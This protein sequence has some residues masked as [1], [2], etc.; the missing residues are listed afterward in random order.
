MQTEKPTKDMKK[1]INKQTTEKQPE[2]NQKRKEII[3]EKN[4]AI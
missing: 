4:A 2:H 1:K 3:C